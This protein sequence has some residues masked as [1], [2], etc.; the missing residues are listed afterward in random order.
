MRPSLVENCL[1]NQQTLHANTLR[2]F[3]K[4]FVRGTKGGV[5]AETYADD[6]FFQMNPQWYGP[7]PPPEMG[8]GNPRQSGDHDEITLEH[9]DVEQ[10]IQTEPKDETI[11]NFPE[12]FDFFSSDGFVSEQFKLFARNFLSNKPQST[13]KRVGTF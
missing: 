5:I 12:L 9:V 1:N 11:D 13:E 6:P 10:P 8:S 2:Q 3:E 7:I 4:R